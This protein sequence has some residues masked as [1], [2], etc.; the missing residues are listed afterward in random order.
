MKYYIREDLKIPEEGKFESLFLEI[1]QNYQPN[2]VIGE[3][4]RVPGTNE[5]EFLHTYE[6]VIYKIKTEHKRIIIGSDQNLDYLKSM[7]IIIL[8]N[9]L[10]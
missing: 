4:F 3:N 8:R 1:P 7:S 10:T 5:A 9:S 2:I 6:N